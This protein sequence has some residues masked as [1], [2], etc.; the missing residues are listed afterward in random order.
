MDKTDEK[1]LKLLQG[2]ARMSW[3]ELGD[4][5]GMSRVAAKKRVKK[6]EEA[7]IIRGYNTT[8]Y[9]EGEVTLLIDIETTPEGFTD[10]LNYMG[11]RTLDIRQIYTT[12]KENHI[13][14]VTVSTSIEN[15]SYMTKMITRHCAGSIE[16]I[17]CHAV[18]EIAKDVYG[19]VGYEQRSKSETDL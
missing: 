15:L 9:R 8:I 13:H 5:I 18:R 7:G 3:Q 14:A 12:T 19:G 2:N 4:A 16:H 1:I 6:L 10:V 17:S 11:T